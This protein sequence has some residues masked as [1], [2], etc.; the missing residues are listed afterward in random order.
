MNGKQARVFYAWIQ[1][2]EIFS[3][4]EVGHQATIN[5]DNL[6]RYIMS[7]RAMVTYFEKEN[8]DEIFQFIT[9]DILMGAPV[10]HFLNVTPHMKS[11]LQAELENEMIRQ[12]RELEKTYKCPT[13]EF[14]SITDTS[15]GS[16]Q[17]CTWKPEIKSRADE[18][19][20]RRRGDFELKK[21][22]KNYKKKGCSAN[23]STETA[24]GV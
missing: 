13:C 20:G 22:C 5:T 16:L 21:S 3:E 2:L 7:D 18:P 23:G 17:D 24:M 8:D 9:D 15:I 1:V 12:Q 14:Y 6:A 19:R 4:I 11:I 10:W